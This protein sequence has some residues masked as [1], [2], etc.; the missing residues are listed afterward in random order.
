MDVPINTLGYICDIDLKVGDVVLLRLIPGLRIQKIRKTKQGHSFQVSFGESSVGVD[1]DLSNL[2][3]VV[4][5]E[6][7][8]AGYTK[9]VGDR[10]ASL[11]T[12]TQD[13]WVGMPTLPALT[14]EEMAKL[15]EA[16][17]NPSWS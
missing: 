9:I 3:V 6:A 13:G 7:V 4:I 11:F 8:K 10:G 15:F 1:C 5:R 12:L 2:A 17:Y 14:N 16:M